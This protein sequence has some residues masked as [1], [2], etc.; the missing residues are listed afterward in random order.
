MGAVWVARNL[1]TEADVAV[2][3]LRHD[4]ADADAAERFRHEAKLG[5]MLGHRNIT[6]VFDLLEDDDGSLVLVMELLRG[7]TLDAHCK[8][9][10]P[11][12]ST[13]AVA[14]IGPILSGLQHAHDHGVVHRDIKPSNIFVH[15][16]PDGHA[17]PKLFDFGIAKVSDSNIH[18]R[19]GEALGTP[20]YMSPEQVRATK[21]LDG[22]SDLFSVGVVLYE[23]IT[24][25]NPFGAPASSAALARVL[26]LEI[27]PHPNLEPRVWL[28]VQR[29][30]SKQAYER[31]G[32]A[33]ELAAALRAAVGE[34]G[35]GLAHSIQRESPLPRVDEQRSRM[36]SES[37][38]VVRDEDVEEAAPP[39]TSRRGMIAA[40]GAAIVL[41]VGLVLLLPASREPS[42]RSAAT[43]PPSVSSASRLPVRAA[44]SASRE[45]PSASSVPAS[46]APHLAAAPSI[47][48][49]PTAAPARH[50]TS[51]A[52]HAAAPVAPAKLVAPASPS[53]TASSPAPSASPSSVA[54]T[55]GF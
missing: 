20:S 24:G 10:G 18:T 44:V 21:E 13:E 25:E 42:S 22:R 33:S 37:P 35:T 14:I 53:P 1:A 39:T 54:R 28:E 43:A 41:A 27:D 34:G 29:A 7:E 11:L 52:P 30:L 50:A 2:K 31:H 48:P 3:V 19:T 45:A 49:T 17:T 46:S 51:H 4:H 15:V 55:P 38:P 36:N 8:S 16:D 12:S 26:E 32:S 47:T 5:A 23:I 6:R 9:R 40:V